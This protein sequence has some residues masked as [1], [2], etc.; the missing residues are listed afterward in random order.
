MRSA[1]FIAFLCL[2]FSSCDPTRRLS[3]EALAELPSS[4]FI[5][6]RHAEKD[7]GD[8]PNLVEKG[9][10]RAE[11]LSGML[12]NLDLD[13]VYSTYFKRC[14]QTAEP[15]ADY[16]GLKI[17][18]FGALELNT[19]AAR[20]KTKHRGETVLVVGHSNTTPELTGLLDRKNDYP[21]FSEL[22]YENLY[23]VTIPP[24]GA[25]QVLKMRF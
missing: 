2:L 8:D 15:T 19:M 10:Q 16:H 5:L 17:Q 1:L 13:A 11:R 9:R 21:R 25:V 3:E 12:Q 23:I 7:Y 6:V 4:I 24:K 20:L 22:D 18:E 14:M